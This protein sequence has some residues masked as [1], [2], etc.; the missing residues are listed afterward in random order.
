LPDGPD[1][2]SALQFTQRQEGIIDWFRQNRAPELAGLYSGAVIMLND[3]RFPGRVRF[4]AHAVREIRN[5]LPNVADE[6]RVPRPLQ[7]KARVDEISGV[8][9][10]NVV[11]PS[12]DERAGVAGA[13]IPTDALVGMRG[14]LYDML[15]RLIQEHRVAG[16]KPR[17]AAERL[18]KARAPEASSS[19]RHM[20]RAIRHWLRVTDW[21]VGCVHLHRGEGRIVDDAGLEAKFAEFED[22]LW[23]LLRPFLEV[24]EELDEIL[25]EANR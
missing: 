24:V 17:M 7:Y 19:Q 20:E 18:I 9:E 3:P 21:F 12:I 6:P 16:E 8:W 22:A 5:E 25:G 15:A 14:L 4:I 10:E 2:P 23:T 11:L 13:E 1:P